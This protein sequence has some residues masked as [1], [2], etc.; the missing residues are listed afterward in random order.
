MH[1]Q[2][3]QFLHQVKPFKDNYVLVKV[4]QQKLLRIENLVNEIISEKP[5]EIR[6]Q[7]D[8]RNSFTRFYTGLMGEAALEE[9]F[10]VDIIDWSAGNS[11]N[12]NHPDLEKTGLNIGVK[13]V[14]CFKFPLITKQNTYPQIICIK[15]TEKSVYICGLASTNTLNTFQDDSLILDSNLRKLNVKT[16]FTGFEH[17]ISLKNISNIMDLKNLTH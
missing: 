17:L 12:Y 16:A 10:G 2:K 15:L 5:K 1:T 8:N 7:K 13:T 14:E 6:H 11:K 4:P 9:Y 3:D